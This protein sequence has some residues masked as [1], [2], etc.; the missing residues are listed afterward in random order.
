MKSEKS[1]GE[2][3]K[4]RVGSAWD[5]GKVSDGKLGYLTN[6]AFRSWQECNGY[7]TADMQARH[8]ACFTRL[9]LGGSHLECRER[10][11]LLE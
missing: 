11:F 5:N 2:D 6:V 10:S 3:F 8:K 9:S 4:Q 7:E 1:L